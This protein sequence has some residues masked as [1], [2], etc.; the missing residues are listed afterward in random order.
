HAPYEKL[1]RAEVQALKTILTR[2]RKI[3]LSSYLV[4]IITDFQFILVFDVV[5]KEV[6]KVK[7]A[8]AQR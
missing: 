1:K 7:I 5:G 8:D 3:D 4:I 6:V 2:L